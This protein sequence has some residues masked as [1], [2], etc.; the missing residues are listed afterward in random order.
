MKSKGPERSP[1]ATRPDRDA[2]ALPS[3][4]PVDHPEP[5]FSIVARKL[6]AAIESGQ[7]PVGSGLPTEHSLAEQFGVSRS[8]IREALC[9]LR[10]NGYTRSARG[11]GTVVVGPQRSPLFGVSDASARDGGAVGSPGLDHSRHGSTEA[12]VPQSPS[13]MIDLLEARLLLEPAAVGLAAGACGEGGSGT[14]LEAVRE[15][16]LGTDKVRLAGGTDMDLHRVLLARCPN[17]ALADAAVRLLD[18]S[19]GPLWRSVR[20]RAWDDG[21]L[22]RRW[23]DDHRRIANSV[24]EGDSAAAAEQMRA[25]LV[26]VLANVAST[27]AL[28]ARERSR[29]SRLIAL[30]DGGHEADGARRSRSGS[31]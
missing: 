6:I 30:G 16:S 28:G 9:C 18:R 20:D 13:E 27:A 26:S 4:G 8:S 1:R 17:G 29:L 22:P 7:I 11:S 10:F 15:I 14:G 21:R 5:V 2:G 19:D 3:F 12:G 31:I 24:L 25:H 23:I